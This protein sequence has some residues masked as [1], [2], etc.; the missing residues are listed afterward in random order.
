MALQ[1]RLKICF[2]L[3]CHACQNTAADLYTCIHFVTYTWRNAGVDCI[4]CT[5]VCH[6]LAP[7]RTSRGPYCFDCASQLSPDTCRDIAICP[8]DQVTYTSICIIDESMFL[9]YY[10]VKVIKFITHTF[11]LCIC[12]YNLLFIS[13]KVVKG[14]LAITLL[15]LLF[16]AN[17]FMMCVNVFHII[18]NKIIAWSDKRCSP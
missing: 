10:F 7:S 18:G 11:C 3:F 13:Y 9:D 17:T 16:L 5:F 6:W 12:I 2:N 14:F 4:N 15:S 1:I 8:S